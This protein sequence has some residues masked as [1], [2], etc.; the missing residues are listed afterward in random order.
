MRLAPQ[1]EQSAAFR[2]QVTAAPRR[3]G[4]HEHSVQ[5]QQHERQRVH[6][7]LYPAARPRPSN[8]RRGQLHTDTHIRSMHHQWCGASLAHAFASLVSTVAPHHTT[9]N[10]TR[11]VSGRLSL[12]HLS[13][14]SADRKS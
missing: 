2:P 14:R 7:A 1:E 12:C 9:Q 5:Q 11:Q 4:H 8:F 10:V 3:H 13:N 6:A